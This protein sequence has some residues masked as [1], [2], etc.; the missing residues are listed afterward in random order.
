MQ[1]V[2]QYTEFGEGKRRDEKCEAPVSLSRSSYHDRRAMGG[3]AVR[4]GQ[5][6]GR[7]DASGILSLRTSE[8][9]PVQQL[10]RQHQPRLLEQVQRC[11]VEHPQRVASQRDVEASVRPQIRLDLP[12]KISTDR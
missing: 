4:R 12:C 7:E 3:V 10:H 11:V 1:P 9:D 5:E 6:T 8:G 2:D